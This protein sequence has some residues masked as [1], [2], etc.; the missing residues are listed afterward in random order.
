MIMIMIIVMIMIT[1]M[2][3]IPVSMKNRSFCHWPLNGQT[4]TGRTE[5]VTV[6]WF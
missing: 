2:M 6:W 1:M 5:K 4:E 3:M